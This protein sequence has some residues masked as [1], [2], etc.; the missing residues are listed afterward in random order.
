LLLTDLRLYCTIIRW[1][2]A[3]FHDKDN[4]MSN[5]EFPDFKQFDD[6]SLWVSELPEKEIQQWKTKDWNKMFEKLI[7]Y[8]ENSNEIEIALKIKNLTKRKHK[9]TKFDVFRNQKSNLLAFAKLYKNFRFE[10]Q[11]LKAIKKSA[12][13]AGK[14]LAQ[15]TLIHLE[16]IAL[17]PYSQCREDYE[18]VAQKISDI[19]LQQSGYSEKDKE[20]MKAKIAYN[21]KLEFGGDTF[22]PDEKNKAEALISYGNGEDFFVEMLMHECVHAYL[23]VKSAH[24]EELWKQGKK[25]AVGLDDDFY[26]LLNYNSL[27]DLD[28]LNWNRIPQEYHEILNAG[29]RKQPFE[30]YSYVY[31]VEAERAYRANSG[32]YSE[33]NAV[34]MSVL[35]SEFCGWPSKIEQK[36]KMVVLK[37]KNPKISP[38]EMLK[39]ANYVFKPVKPEIVKGFNI[40]INESNEVVVNVPDMYK[41]KEAMQ[42]YYMLV[43]NNPQ[44]SYFAY[45]RNKAANKIDS[46]TGLKLSEKSIHPK[47]K[48]AE[49]IMA[50]KR[51]N[52]VRNK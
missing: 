22:F 11:Q 10:P 3:I 48:M 45:L 12:K 38:E 29:Y 23:Q 1:L 19:V 39:R 28:S 21:G 15:D 20:Q 8:I 46:V 32:K 6:F 44:I 2:S 40:H 51:K 34:P 25:P 52:Y 35:L 7:S 13:E 49:K 16:N 37:Y 42:L 14:Q 41:C 27:F 26:K 5:T 43:A 24:Q 47:L 36:N 31:G 30:K 18:Y 33:R 17:K 4:E 50:N 9:W